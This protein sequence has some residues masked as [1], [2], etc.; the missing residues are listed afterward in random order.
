M[1]FMFHEYVWEK[2]MF[3][4]IIDE[5][6]DYNNLQFLEWVKTE[7]SHSFVELKNSVEM[8]KCL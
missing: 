7:N 2:N 8:E 1:M 5:K 6:L 4:D 3:Q